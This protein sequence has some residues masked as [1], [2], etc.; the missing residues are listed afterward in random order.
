MALG[1]FGHLRPSQACES[2]KDKK[3]PRVAQPV[4]GQVGGHQFRKLF[5]RQMPVKFRGSLQFVTRKRITSQ[6]PVLDGKPDYL[7][8]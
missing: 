3:I 2:R 5:A 8:Q 1:Q 7:A 4:G 6:Y